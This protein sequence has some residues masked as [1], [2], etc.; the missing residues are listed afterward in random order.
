M[1]TPSRRGRAIGGGRWRLVAQRLGSPWVVGLIGVLVVIGVGIGLVLGIDAALDDQARS[2]RTIQIVDLTEDAFAVVSALQD[3]RGFAA[4]FLIDRTEETLVPYLASFERTDAAANDLVVTW[5]GQVTV[6]I[7]SDLEALIGPIEELEAVRQSLLESGGDESAIE[8]YAG[9]LAPLSAELTALNSRAGVVQLS[10]E[11]TLIELIAAAE[12]AGVRRSIGARILGVG[13]GVT[14]EDEVLLR[15]ETRRLASRLDAVGADTAISE[16]IEDL[17]GADAFDRVE[18]MVSEMLEGGSDGFSFTEAEWFEASTGQ[19]DRIRE[20]AMLVAGDLHDAAVGEAADAEDRL[21]LVSVLGG[22]LLF[23][24]VVAAWGAVSASRDR[25]SA[26]S[27]HTDLVDR[28]RSWFVPRSLPAVPGLRL[29]VRYVPAPGGVAAGGDWYDVIQ[30]SDGSV[31]FVIGDVAGHGPAAV[32]RMAELKNTLRGVVATTDPDPAAQ[33]GVLDAATVSSHLLATACYSILDP[34]AGVL[35]YSRAGHLPVLL[36]RPGGG[37]TVLDEAGGPPLGVEAGLV[38][39][40][41]SV[42]VAPGSVLL[43]FTDGLIEEPGG[44]VMRSVRRIARV[45]ETAGNDLSHLAD[46][47]LAMRPNRPKADDLSLLIAHWT[48]EGRDVG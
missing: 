3:E 14:R 5:T 43:M 26:L 25:L 23:I 15:V 18:E 42:E 44:D 4:R 21:V 29:E 30:R 31:G 40:S 45:F 9:L 6:G 2:K 38:R 37:V 39:S 47:L 48:A 41:A 22:A 12:A 35:R 16:D 17:V 13:E 34:N 20:A 36:R 46:L 7:E 32:A 10:P 28:L 24:A 19:V 27:A 33:L 8:L 11:G 1:T